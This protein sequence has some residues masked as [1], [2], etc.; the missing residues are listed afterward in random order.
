MQK[1]KKNT[2]NMY[3]CMFVPICRYQYSQANNI[4]IN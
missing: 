2:T 3:V 1:K 4:K